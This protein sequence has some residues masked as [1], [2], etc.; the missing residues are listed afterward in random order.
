MAPKGCSLTII[1]CEIH[2]VHFDK[3]KRKAQLLLN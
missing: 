3:R 1:T 2:G